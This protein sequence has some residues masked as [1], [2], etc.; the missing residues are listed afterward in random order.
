MHDD[1]DFEQ[2]QI[3]E[4][5]IDMFTSFRSQTADFSILIVCEVP[6]VVDR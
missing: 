6:K 2:A 3:F 5:E 1:D 4:T